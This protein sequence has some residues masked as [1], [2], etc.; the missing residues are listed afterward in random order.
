M[1][2]TSTR[3]RLAPRIARGEV[4]CATCHELIEVGQPWNIDG[5]TALHAACDTTRPA[6]PPTPS[7]VAVET[8]RHGERWPGEFRGKPERNSRVW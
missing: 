2:D 3:R 7:T 5:G 4:V 1:N 6:A 8:L